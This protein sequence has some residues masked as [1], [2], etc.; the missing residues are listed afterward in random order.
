MAIPRDLYDVLVAHGMPNVGDIDVQR[1]WLKEA[2]AGGAAA[3]NEKKQADDSDDVVGIPSPIIPADQPTPQLVTLPQMD[4]VYAPPP[5]APVRSRKAAVELLTLPCPTCTTA[6]DWN[7]DGP[8]TVTCALCGRQYGI[9]E[10]SETVSR[11]PAVIAPRRT[12]QFRMP[13]RNSPVPPVHESNLTTVGINE[14][15]QHPE[16]KEAVIRHISGGQPS[17]E[18]LAAHHLQ[19]KHDTHQSSLVYIDDKHAGTLI[20]DHDR[21]GGPIVRYVKV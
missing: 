16:V 2:L 19:F 10:T 1:E 21:E 5:P 14:A 9:W 7:P 6:N 20:L 17:G 8:P 4:D 11:E 13:E 15:L 3:A 12:N 18:F